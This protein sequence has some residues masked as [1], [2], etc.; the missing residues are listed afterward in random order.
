MLVCYLWS[1]DTPRAMHQDL[2]TILFS[3][4][5]I[6]ARLDELA[7]EIT[8][9]FAGRE[10]TVVAILHGSLP[11][12]ADLLRRVPLPL[13]I[14]CVSVSSYHGGTE[15]SGTV[16]INQLSLP[17][18]EGQ[19]VL[20]LDDILDTGRT[21]DAIG[22]KLKQECSPESLRICVLL[23][24]HTERAAEVHADYVGFEIADQFVVGYGL[25]YCG[26]YRN[27]PCIGTLR[28]ELAD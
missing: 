26:R 3:E 20:V 28:Q 13:K 7:A 23:D 16:T 2:D 11:F 12:A 25:D 19:H 22:R 21:L 8:R 14:E 24:K 17:N 10:M 6:H 9:D 4:Q 15:S 5:T 18:L 1:G 27:L